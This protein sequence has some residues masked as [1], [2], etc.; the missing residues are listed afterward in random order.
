MTMLLL[1]RT[2]DMTHWHGTKGDADYRHKWREM[3]NRWTQSGIREDNQSGY[4]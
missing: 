3:G 4:T 1:C 2:T